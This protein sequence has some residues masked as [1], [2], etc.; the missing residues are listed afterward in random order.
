MA[1]QPHVGD[2]YAHGWCWDRW[3]FYNGYYVPRVQVDGLYGLVGYTEA[4][5]AS[6]EEDMYER[7]AVPTDV[8]L[9][10]Y[11]EVGRSQDFNV[12]IVI[13]LDP[14]GVAKTVRLHLQDVLWDWP[15]NTDERYNNGVKQGFELG[16]FELT[17]GETVTVTHTI[18]FDD[19]SWSNQD[20]IRIAAYVHDPQ[21]AAPAEVYQSEMV[22]WPLDPPGCKGDVNS[23][24]MVD[25]DDVFDVLSHWGEGTGQYDVN[26][27]GIVDIDDLFDV[28]YLWGPC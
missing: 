3:Y 17:P 5:Y 18:T 12:T 20:R 24:E 7:L 16:D 14:D 9:E 27:D 19:E 1:I 6:L 28:L 23:D 15:Y 21:P 25:I 26:N 13:G 2:S 11:G 10:L 8:T 22:Q 4:N